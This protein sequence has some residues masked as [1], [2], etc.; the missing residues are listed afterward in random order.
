MTP[1]DEARVRELI[2]ESR[3]DGC[4]LRLGY[5]CGIAF[6]VHFSWSEDG[7]PGLLLRLGTILFGHPPV[8]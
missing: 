7:L 2:R 8:N 1:Q 5:L 3:T 4:V 6:L